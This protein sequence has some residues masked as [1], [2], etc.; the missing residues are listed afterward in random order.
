LSARHG[1][2]GA[3]RAEELVKLTLFSD[4][5]LRQHNDLVHFYKRGKA[6][7]HTDDCSVL[8]QLIDGRL[9]LRFGSGGL[10]QARKRCRPGVA[11]SVRADLRI[12]REVKNRYRSRSGWKAAP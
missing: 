10:C 11:G 9:N 3:I 5:S 6:M 2:E 8:R 12:R 7:S 4:S 1:G